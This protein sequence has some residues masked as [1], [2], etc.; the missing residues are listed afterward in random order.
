MRVTKNER[1]HI[2]EKWLKIAEKNEI[3]R[4]INKSSSM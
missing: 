1:H 3:K 2:A 4:G